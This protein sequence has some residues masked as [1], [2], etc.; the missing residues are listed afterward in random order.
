MFEFNKEALRNLTRQ[1][2]LILSLLVVTGVFWG[3]KLTGI[4]MAG[5]AFCGKTEHEHTEECYIE[6]AECLLEE[7]I[8]VGN[9]YSNMDADIETRLDWEA[10]VAD[11]PAGG[12]TSERVAAVARS[13]LGY[14]ESTLN[15]E[16]DLEGV[17]RGITRYG[18]WYGN[19][20]G[21]WSAMFASF[22]LH[23]AGAEGLPANAGAE[24]MRL[25]WAAEELYASVDEYSPQ[26]GI[27]IFLREN[28]EAETACAVAVISEVADDTIVLIQGN[29][30]DAVAES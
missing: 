17:R 20:Y 4:T 29:I 6:G 15:F 19:P 25:E 30:D 21:D 11:V 13:Q 12:S 14:T 2:L 26:T 22:C 7:H 27:L 23:Y 9:C 8:H 16:V 24:S 5:E 3:L 18:Q 10:A 28:A 1:L